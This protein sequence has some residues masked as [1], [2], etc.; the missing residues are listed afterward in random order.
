MKWNGMVAK[1][2]VPEMQRMQLLQLWSPDPLRVVRLGGAEERIRVWR[3]GVDSDGFNPRFKSA[4][5]RKML[6]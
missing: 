6:S 1:E 3:K 2:G 4:E 5:Y